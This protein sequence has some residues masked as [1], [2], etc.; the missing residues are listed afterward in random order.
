MF[1]PPCDT[2]G[3]FDLLETMVAVYETGQFT[4]AAD[5]LRVSQS[6]V[7]SRIAQLERL[8]GAPLF[9]RHAKSDVTPT[10]AGRVLYATATSIGE[11]WRDV[12]ERIAREQ[13]AK[14][15]FILLLSHTAAS[16][17]LPRAAATLGDALAGFDVAVRALNSDAILAHIGRKGAQLGI[18]EKPIADDAVQRVTL[19]HDRLV[20]A[21][22]EGAEGDV[23]LVREHGS[24]VRYYTDLYLK[25]SGEVPERTMEVSS[26]AAIVACLASGFGRSIVSRAAVPDGVPCKDLGPEFTRR[27]YALVPRSGL[28]RGQRALAGQIVA[29]L[30]DD[31]G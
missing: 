1:A 13:A 8:V 27:F 9:D 11:Q 23:L 4:I 14:E 15:E 24:G 16:V 12:R 25:M 3:M 21:G 6:T 30:A 7:S 18:V 10:E 20:L 26:N 22:G 2:R 29:A 28:S 5:E 17:L 19:C 31:A